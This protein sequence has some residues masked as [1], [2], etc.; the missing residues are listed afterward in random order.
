MESTTH[1]KQVL[2]SMIKDYD[3]W[4]YLTVKII[5]T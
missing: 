5:E 2:P 4:L 3:K 1:D